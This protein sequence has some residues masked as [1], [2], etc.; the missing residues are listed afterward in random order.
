MIFPYDSWNP[1]SVTEIDHLFRN[2]PFKWGLAGGYAVEQF[3]GTS[4]RKHSDIDIIVFRNDQYRLYQWLTNWALYAADPPGTLR[5]WQPTEWLAP[6]IHD[7]WA[8]Q[9]NARAWQ[10]QIMIVDI[11]GDRWVSRRHPQICGLQTDLIVTY[12]QLPCIRIEVQLLYKAKAQREKDWHDF[13][14][15]LP[16]LSVTAKVWLKQALELAHPEGHPWHDL[17]P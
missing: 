17:I 13:Q 6:S 10:F 14:S 8:H 9:V 15:C 11:E 12:H 7:I 3:L 1:L 4:I 16:H 2:A 5:A